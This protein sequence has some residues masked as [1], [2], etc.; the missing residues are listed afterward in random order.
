VLQVSIVGRDSELDT[1][2]QHVLY[3]QRCSAVAHAAQG[4]W[5]HRAQSMAR[6]RVQRSIKHNDNRGYQQI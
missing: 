2:P 3:S 1:W 6:H 5:R 4:T